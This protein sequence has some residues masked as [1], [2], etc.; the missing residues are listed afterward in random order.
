[1]HKPTEGNEIEGSLAGPAG[2]M[3]KPNP[4]VKTY[5]TSSTVTNILSMTWD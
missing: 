3:P 2:A 1:M 4:E 5:C